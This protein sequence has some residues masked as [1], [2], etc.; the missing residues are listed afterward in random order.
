MAVSVIAVLLVLLCPPAAGAPGDPGVAFGLADAPSV[1]M[2]DLGFSPDLAFYGQSDVEAVRIPVVAGLIPTALSANV[3]APVFVRGA[4][5]TVIQNDREIARLDIPLGGA[6]APLVIP[7]AGVRVVDNAVTLDVRTYALADE[8]YCLDPT[9]PLRLTD[10]TVTFAGIE[11][12]PTTI[13]DFLP[14]VLRRL[15]VYIAAKPSLGEADAAVQLAAAVAAH[16][17]PQNPA[18]GLVALQDPAVPPPGS[19]QPFER[20][21]VITEGPDAGLSLQPNAGGVPTLVVSGPIEALTNQVRLITSGVARYAL[22]SAAVVGPLRSVPQLPGNRTTIR[23]LGQPG[24]NSTALSP[25]VYI[26]LDQARLGRSAHD[27]R[28][29]LMG[30]YTPLPDSIGGRLVATVGGETIDRWPVTREG[31]INRWIDVPD[32]LLQRYTNLRVK[33]DIAGD[34]G[35][36][37]EFQPLTLTIDGESEVQSTPAS[38]PIPAGFQSMPQS[39][40]PRVRIGIGDDIFADARRATLIVIGMQRLSPL[41]LDTVV[42][43]LQQAID[44]KDPAVLISPAGWHYPE[45]PLPVVAPHAVPM[46]I[47]V[48][49]DTGQPTTLTLEPALP[50]GSLQT[51]FDGRRSLLVATSNEAP[52]Q[53]D[54]L[55]RWLSLD[56]RR[57]PTLSGE[58]VLSVPGHDPVM[59]VGPVVAAAPETARGSR[60]K[61]SWLAGGVLAVVVGAAAGWLWHRR[62]RASGG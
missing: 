10:L 43:P 14:P 19:G 56:R 50:F 62:R 34:T 22:S 44:S 52:E 58:A 54:E 35:R 39:L 4:R 31:V 49:D 8:G 55:I 7:L 1:P 42:V 28:V 30:S 15:T 25:E 59:V 36:C 46:T 60:V 53:L 18:I 51:V 57:V 26:G 40:M 23:R 61:I 6:P 2:Q 24:V 20:Q 9:N 16:Y 27:L 5:L 45:V 11:V 12:A 33:L 17:G 29:H 13:A 48:E 38:P 3:L 21:I 41:P 37:G 32:R 47:N